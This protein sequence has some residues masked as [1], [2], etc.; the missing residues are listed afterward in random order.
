MSV[1]RNDLSKEAVGQ[2]AKKDNKDAASV[3][4][5]SWATSFRKLFVTQKIY[6]E[7]AI[8][9]I[10]VLGKFNELTLRSVYTHSS[11]NS[12]PP[13]SPLGSSQVP[14]MQNSRSSTPFFHP[15]QS[16]EQ[17]VLITGYKEAGTYVHQFS[18]DNDFC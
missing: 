9:D 12:S 13:S 3:Y 8:E 6:A 5:D 14:S 16:Y 2:L 17:A 18:P 10:L 15:V 1:G 11:A 7:K 4:A